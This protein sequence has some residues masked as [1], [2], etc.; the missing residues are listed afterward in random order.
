MLTERSREGYLLIDHRNSPGTAAVGPG[1]TFESAT[2]T[3]FHCQRIVVLNPDRTRERYR[4]PDC[5]RYVCDQCAAVRAA[6]GA[7]TP[8]VKRL[9]AQYELICREATHGETQL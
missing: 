9:E 6:G 2:N 8:F 3:C 1:V 7:C 4:C 5:F